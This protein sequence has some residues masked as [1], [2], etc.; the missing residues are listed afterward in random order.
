MR[1]Q[2]SQKRGKILIIASLAKS[3]INFRL[4]LLQELQAHGFEVVTCAG[5]DDSSVVESL[6]KQSVCHHKISLSNTKINPFKDLSDCWRLVKFIKRQNPDIVLSYTIKPVIYGSLAGWLAGVRNICSMVTGLG[7]VFLNNSLKGKIIRFFVRFLYRR[8]LCFNQAV[9]FQNPEDSKL[10]VDNRLVNKKQVCQINGSGVNIHQF[11]TRPLPK[12]CS[13]LLIARLIRDKGIY[14]YIAAARQIK[15]HYPSICFKLVGW[16]DS[17]PASLQQ[18]A[19][20]A[21]SKEGVIEYLGRLTDVRPAIESCSVYVLPSYREGTP[22]SVLE[23]MAMGRPIITTDVPGCRETVVDGVNGFLVPAR[24]VDK[25]VSTMEQ[26][27]LNPDL[28]VSM[29]E[30]S[31]KIAK[32]KYDVRKVNQVI[33][34]RVLRNEK[35]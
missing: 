24:N 27:I 25:L 12:Q 15:K 19:L 31:V 14:E 35:S 5:D 20:D 33:L 9:F 23:A 6:A 2:Q 26:F 21:W 22:R 16:I 34:S 7:Y 30:E 1:N 13:F 3:L 28:I 11:C 32:E 18:S 17:N 4:D 10:F 8:S 29:G